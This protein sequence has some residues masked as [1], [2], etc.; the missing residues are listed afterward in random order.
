MDQEEGEEEGE[1]G[2]GGEAGAPGVKGTL[3]GEEAE[4]VGRFISNLS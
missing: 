2:R 3:R 1:G 4:L